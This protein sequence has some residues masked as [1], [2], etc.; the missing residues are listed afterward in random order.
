MAKHLPEAFAE[1][2][3]NVL[4]SACYPFTNIILRKMIAN[5]RVPRPGDYA[6][7]FPR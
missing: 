3:V 5:Y 6:R 4:S 1:S 2:K 7:E